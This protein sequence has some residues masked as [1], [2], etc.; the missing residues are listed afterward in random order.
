PYVRVCA[1]QYQQRML[2]GF[3]EFAQSCEYFID[4]AS[5]YR[6]DVVL[7]PEMFTM[8]LLTFLPQ[9]HPGDAVRQL[10]KFT[11][12]YIQLFTSLAIKYTINIIAG[13][14]FVVEIDDLYNAAFLS[15]RNGSYEK[16]YKIHITPHEKKWWGV[17][18]GKKVEV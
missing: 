17:K 5:D 12:D 15:R 6:C 4:V 7:F 2:K 1:V 10:D 11:P 9:E 18:P 3:G 16:Q 13:S 14:H 8:Q